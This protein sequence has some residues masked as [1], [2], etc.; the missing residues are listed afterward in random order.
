MA[1]P[2]GEKL[3]VDNRRARYEY[4]LLER[5]EAGVALTGTEVKSLRDGRAV[6]DVAAE[7]AHILVAL[8]GSGVVECAGAAPASFN[9]GEAVIVPA[10]VGEY[11]LKGQWSAELL[12]ALV[13]GAPQRA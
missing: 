7:S 8:E 13:P 3:I 12:Q 11:S 6:R 4:E 1:R 10:S 9:K 5:L 2:S